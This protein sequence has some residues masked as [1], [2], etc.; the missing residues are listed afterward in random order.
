M[1]TDL[2]LEVRK[3]SHRNE[4]SPPTQIQSLEVSIK[5]LLIHTALLEWPA[6]HS[7]PCPCADCDEEVIP[8]QMEEYL[9]TR[10]PLLW[11]CGLFY[12]EVHAQVA[13]LLGIGL[14]VTKEQLWK[15]PFEDC[16]RTFERYY[17][18]VSYIFEG[19]TFYESY[20]YRTL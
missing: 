3:L 16:N 6:P 8:E 4:R 20:L 2:L 12:T 13:S 15:C 17:E 1:F 11:Q 9:Q 10:H 18:I 14:E 19:H 5:D 7:H